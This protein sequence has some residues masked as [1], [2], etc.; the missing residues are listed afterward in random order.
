V[1]NPV[2]IATENF[3]KTIY[4]FDRHRGEDTRPGSIAKALQISNAAATDMA[5]KLAKKEL[6]TYEKYKALKLTD[7]GEKMA[8]GIIRK[9]RLWET[10][11]F[12]VFGMG[13]HEIHREAELLEHLTSDFLAE[14]ISHFLGHPTADPHGD[15]IPDAAGAYPEIPELI[16]LSN[17]Q[18]N[19]LY[20]ISRL[21]GTDKSFF[22]FCQSRGLVLGARITVKQQIN[23][24][25]MTEIEMDD[26][27]LLLHAGMTQ[28]VFV[29]PIE[30]E[31]ISTILN[32]KNQI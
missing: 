17:S 9:H 24:P 3:I 13:M 10:F 18:P 25:R 7:S 29:R 28:T 15:P 30:S 32:P 1:K 14:K 22:D 5:R 26:T 8:L 6:I 19:R 31:D 2:S 11:L 20:E 27:V 12:E 4:Q 23:S 21:S 16:L